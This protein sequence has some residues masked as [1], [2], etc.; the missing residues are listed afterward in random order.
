MLAVDS[1]NDDLRPHF[2]SVYAFCRLVDDLGDELEGDRLD[3][4]DRWED[5]LASLLLRFAKTHLVPSVATHD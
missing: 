4:L 3:L 5:E 1:S 2:Y